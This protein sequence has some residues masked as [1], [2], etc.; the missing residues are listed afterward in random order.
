MQAKGHTVAMTGDGVNDVLALKEADC[1]VAM[2]AG[3]EAARNVSQLVLINNDFSSMPKV[4]AEG[5]R[6][7]NNIQRS[8]SLF[9]IKTLYSIVLAIVFIF[10]SSAYPFQPIQLS[11]VGGLTIGLPSFVLALQPNHDR[12]KGDFFANVISRAIPG[13]F[14]IIMNIVL[15][16]FVG[17][18]FGF[19]SND[20][21]TIAVYLTA[22][23]GVLMVIRLSIPFNGIRAALLCVIVTGLL[24]GFIFIRNILSLTPLNTVEVIFALILATA[25]FVIFNVLY[26]VFTSKAARKYIG[27]Q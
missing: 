5:R 13:A 19:D 12:I 26:S 2:A 24:G 15:V 17:R 23:V 20:I 18:N 4:V 3:S 14:T 9:L 8:A 21:S 6:A 1:S 16:T 7:I 27:E 11:F 22:F 10:V 25:S